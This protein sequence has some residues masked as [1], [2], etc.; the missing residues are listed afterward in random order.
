M[1]RIGSLPS[2]YWPVSV[3]GHPPAGPTLLVPDGSSTPPQGLR[4]DGGERLVATVRTPGAARS[5]AGTAPRREEGSPARPSGPL[6]ALLEA[7]PARAPR[8]GPSSPL[9]LPTACT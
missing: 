3:S 2:R 7:E 6:W 9:I 1:T 4:F 8:R 5:L